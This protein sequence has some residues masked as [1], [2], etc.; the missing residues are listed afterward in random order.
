MHLVMSG[1]A[2]GVT[3]F[4]VVSEHLICAATPEQDAVTKA[5]KLEIADQ[6]RQILI[7]VRQQAHLL[8]APGVVLTPPFQVIL[9]LKFCLCNMIVEQSAW[10]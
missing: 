1:G 8:H 9:Q 4:P 5:T 3:C 6:A 7:S 2:S 10:S